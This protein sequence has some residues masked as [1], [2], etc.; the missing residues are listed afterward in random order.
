MLAFMNRL[1][2]TSTASI[3]GVL[4]SIL[5]VVLGV[6]LAHF[7]LPAANV[8]SEWPHYG[9][10][11]GGM[12]FSRLAQINR[13]NIKRLQP[14]WTYHTGDISDGTGYSTRSTFEC[15]PIVSDGVLYLTTPFC[16][17]IALDAESG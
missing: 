14:A 16:R 2:S 11:L 15:T 5:V 1:K 9:N 13:Q 12:R 17:V 4:L 3:P 10:D 7:T 6:I 8:I